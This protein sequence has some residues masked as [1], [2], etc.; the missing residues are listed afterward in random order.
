MKARTPHEIDPQVL[1]RLER[2][3]I[4]KRLKRRQARV[5]L[6]IWDAAR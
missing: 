1:A 2:A 6:F 4:Q 5:F 3:R